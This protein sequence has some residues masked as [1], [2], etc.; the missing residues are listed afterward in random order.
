MALFVAMVLSFISR[1]VDLFARDD[2]ALS[3]DMVFVGSSLTRNFIPVESPP[4]GMFKDG[5]THTRVAVDAIEES[6]SNWIVEKVL[7][8]RPK[9]VFVEIYAYIRE[10]N[11]NY[12][13][14]KAE[15]RLGLGWLQEKLFAL[16]EAE[17]MTLRFLASKNPLR[18]KTTDPEYF[19]KTGVGL[20]R[21]LIIAYPV[22]YRAQKEPERLLSIVRR[23][24]ETGVCLVFLAQSNSEHTANY[25]GKQSLNELTES[26]LTFERTYGVK[27]WRPAELVWPNEL[28][29][30][31]GHMNRL[32]RERYLNEL[33]SAKGLCS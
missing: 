27:V 15:Q 33:G 7:E 25:V 5:R 26:I 10:F 22:F 17:H 23:A 2:F 28:Y 29:I 30:D 13:I 12:V 11:R 9:M 14:S 21:D 31:E 6:Q 16:S 1:E 3:K 19:D 4:G 18:Y 20:D 8:Q 32:G 24:K